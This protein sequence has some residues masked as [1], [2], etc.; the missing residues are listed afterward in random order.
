[1]KLTKRDWR[2]RSGPVTFY[3]HDELVEGM[4][5]AVDTIKEALNGTAR[6]TRS[7]FIANAIARYMAALKRRKNGLPPSTEF[8][9]PKAAP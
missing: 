1:M 5:D 8:Q 9:H 6:Y 4:D 7:V 2:A 3:A